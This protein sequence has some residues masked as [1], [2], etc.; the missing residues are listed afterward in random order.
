MALAFAAIIVVLRGFLADLLTGECPAGAR[1]FL[2]GVY[3]HTSGP[4]LR[5]PI[6]DQTRPSAWRSDCGQKRWCRVPP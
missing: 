5:R 3:R 4:N 2:V 6:N 1:D